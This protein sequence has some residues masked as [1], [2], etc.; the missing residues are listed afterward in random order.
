MTFS[1]KQNMIFFKNLCSLIDSKS[2]KTDLSIRYNQKAL[3]LQLSVQSHQ[4]LN[5]K[6]LYLL[7]QKMQESL[8]RSQ[9]KIIQAQEVPQ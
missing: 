2:F 4:G 9:R 6:E 7:K 3:T 5:P 8:S 1:L